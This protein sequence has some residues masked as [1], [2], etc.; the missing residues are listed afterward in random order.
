[1]SFRHR[2]LDRQVR[3]YLGPDAKIPPEWEGLLHAVEEAYE[4]FDKDRRLTEHA[5]MLS[6]EEIASRNDRLVAENAQRRAVQ[7]RL[8]A[9]VRALRLDMMP[10]HALEDDLM[11]LTA[12]LDRLIQQRNAAETA[13]RAAKE[14]AEA[15]NR[16]KS[17][18]LANMSHEIRTPMNAVLGM[19][20]LLLDL[21][22]SPEQREYVETIRNSGDALLEIL[23][24][25]LDFSK[26]ESGKL[27]LELH[28]FD[29]RS[30]VEQVIDLFVARSAEKGIELGISAGANVPPLVMGDSTRLR[31]VLVNLVGNAIKFT[32][33]GGVE[34]RMDATRG[35]S[36]WK[37]SFVVEDSGIGIPPDRIDRL[38]KSFSQVDASITRRF[39]GTGLGLAISSRLV[40][41]MGGRIVVTSELGR[42]SRFAF[43]VDVG[44]I[45]AP[46]AGVSRAQPVD[47]HGRSV[48]VVDDNAINRRIL[49]RQLTNWGMSV[50]IAENGPAALA[51]FEGG[52]TFDLVLLDMHMPGMSGVDVATA[53]NVTPGVRVPPIILLTSRG[54]LGREA[55][56]VAV[57]MA[58]PVKPSEL[59]ASILEVLGHASPAAMKRPAAV[60]PFDHHFAKRRPLRILIAE[61]NS[62]NRKLI[63]RMLERLGYQST[64]VENGRDVL[65]ALARDPWSLVLM[66]MQMPEMDGLEATRRLRSVIPVHAPP[67]VLAL[68]AN[69]RREDY[70]A[71]LAVG[72]QDFLSKPVRSED[73]MAAL[74]RAYDWLQEEDRLTQVKPL[75]ELAAVLADR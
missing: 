5:M 29:P 30:C 41:L 57:Q 44:D 32:D 13:M 46:N 48:L 11:A 63:V 8:Q 69:A 6:S 49:E 70:D 50:D 22:L 51:F 71:C 36:G 52:R 10:D 2:L 54:S 39:G 15:A 72:M 17:E 60:S 67:Y 24:D 31:Q 7:E 20:S 45:A 74:S 73:L 65:A 34:V 14:A 18:F 56:R 53:L 38:F 64:A 9:S 26:I 75:P 35:A 1:M 12:V 47:L 37:L 68:T 25:I 40:E 28:A 66:D 58:K 42:G 59:Y 62:V 21:S 19:S 33:Q 4:Q 55:E 23:N 16:A 27:E 61:D 3:K 43:E